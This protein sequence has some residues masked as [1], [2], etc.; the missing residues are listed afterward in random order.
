MKVDVN[1]ILSPVLEQLLQRDLGGAINAMEAFLSSHPRENDADRL[2]AIKTDYQ[3][4]ADYWRHGF[5]DPQLTALYGNLLKRM[6]VLYANAAISQDVARSAYFSSLYVKVQMTSRDRQPQTITAELEAFVQDVAVLQ[7][8]PEHQ[9]KEKLKNLYRKH[10][11]VM[12]DLFDYILTSRIWTDGMADSMEA[13][14][15][16]PTI[17]SNDQQ[18]LV[19]AIMLS[20]TEHFDIAKFRLLLNVYKQ[21]TDEQVRQRALVGWV[22]ALDAD[23]GRSIYPEELQLVEQLLEDEACCKELTELQKQ[24]IYCVNTEADNATIQ[25]EIMPDLLK[26]PGLRMTQHGLEEQ[27]EDTLNDILHPDETERTLEKVEASFHRMMD[28]QKQGSDIYFGGFSQMKRFPFFNT[29]SNWFCPFFIDHADVSIAKENMGDNRFLKMMLAHGP[30][31]NSDK[32]SFLLAFEQVAA[33][34]PQNMREM[35]ERGEADMNQVA[36][37]EEQT[38]TYIRRTYL[39]DLYRFFRV[40]PYRGEFRLQMNPQ[41]MEYLF[42]SSPIFQSTHLEPFFNEVTAFLIKKKRYSETVK[43]LGNYS[44]NRKDF[45]FYMMA[46]FLAQ[47]YNM[48]DTGLEALACYEKA[49]ELEPGNERAMAGYARCLFSDLRY[50]EALEAYETLLKAQP[51][52]KSYLLN[53]AICLQNLSRNEEALKLLYRLNYEAPDDDNVSRVLAWTLTCDGKYS[54]AEKIY[55]QLLSVESPLPGDMLNFG[56]CLWFSGHIDDAADC[57]HRF[58]KETGMDPNSILENEQALINAKGI[59]EPEQKMMLYIL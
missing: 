58:M 25:R 5:K 1:E 16:S 31:C 28:M 55:N 48:G 6:Y 21:S 30:F 17:D 24:L 53:K 40:F 44:K 32:Y 22:F 12:T 38:P 54:Q 41:R 4:M 50:D 42:F 26:Q 13:L 15:L 19:S 59:T 2:F 3:M 36:Q 51:D 57:F 43:M 33:Q 29:L 14:L 34:I 47:R 11:Y 18:L 52:K 39:Q 23:L 49:L 10:Q 27:E 20:A 9:V 8:E 35:L 46:G 37:E 56:Y 7:L 45:Q